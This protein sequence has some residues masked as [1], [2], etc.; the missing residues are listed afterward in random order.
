[1]SM[2]NSVSTPQLRHSSP[3]L[4]SI[5]SS[6][7]TPVMTVVRLIISLHSQVGPRVHGQFCSHALIERT[8]LIR[9]CSWRYNL[10]HHI[11]ITRRAPR[12]PSAF[13]AQLAASL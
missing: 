4:K 11:L 2:M 6:S 12:Q 5:V 1:M 7:T 9:T 8:R 13:Q 10:E 3:R